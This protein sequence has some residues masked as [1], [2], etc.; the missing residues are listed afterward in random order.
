[1]KASLNLLARF[2][3]VFLLG[4]G[5][6][7][8]VL[9]AVAV[10]RAGSGYISSQASSAVIL[11]YSFS[12]AI[13][14][15]WITAVLINLFSA[16]HKLRKTPL[17]LIPVCIAAG[18][19]LFSIIAVTENI[20]HGI[21]DREQVYSVYP[22]ENVIYKS[23]HS[24]VLIQELDQN[25]VR[26]VLFLDS[27]GTAPRIRLYTSLAYDSEQQLLTI[28][29]NP[30]FNFRQ[31]G[32]APWVLYNPPSELQAVI[33]D[34]QLLQGLLHNSSLIVSFAL[35][36]ALTLSLFSLW[37]LVRFTRW[38]LL[39]SVLVISA[40]RLL[41]ASVSLFT[42]PAAVDF[43]TIVIGTG[44]SA[45]LPALFMS[46]FALSLLAAGLLMQPFSRWSQEVR[47]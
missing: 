9:F 28:P 42:D 46:V 4:L 5:L 8:L 3:A 37:T 16:L 17:P 47:Q 43:F 27:E 44:H 18:L 41:L 34:V 2:L 35:G 19:L 11:W 20:S 36:I 40:L 1:M 45:W 10:G 39:N 12:Q 33:N 31:A 21:S 15:A 26:N 13:L 24:A 22:A 29:D 14:P 38:P 7:T 25:N 30:D 23:Q 32:N 6:F